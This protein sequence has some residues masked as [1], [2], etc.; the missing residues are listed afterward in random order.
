MRAAVDRAA[1]DCCT[2]DEHL[3]RCIPRGWHERKPARQAAL[4][5]V[6]R[7]PVSDK[8]S[9]VYRIGLRAGSFA[10]QSIAMGNAARAVAGRMESMSIAPKLLLH[11]RPGFRRS[12]AVD[13]DS[14]LRDRL[15][16]ACEDRHTVSPRNV[17]R[18]R[19][20]TRAAL[21]QRE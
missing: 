5:A 21:T 2:V 16:A 6:L 4:R 14:L 17:P 19:A 12:L 1:I 9:P 11:A 13:I 10:V 8:L 7:D 18:G 3:L 15:C 20:I